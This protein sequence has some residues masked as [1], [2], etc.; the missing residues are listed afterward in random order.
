MR[1]IKSHLLEYIHNSINNSF[2]NKNI[3]FL[4]LFSTINENL[5]KDY[6]M[7]L[8]T[9]TIKDLYENSPISKKYRRQQVDNSDINKKIIQ[10]IY[11]E[12]NLDNLEFEVIKILNSTYKDL[13]I[14]FRDKYFNEFLEDIE[15]E[16]KGK[17]ETEENIKKYKENI[18]KLCLNYEDWFKKKN[19]RKRNK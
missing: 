16:E 13:L 17:G 8:M 10:Q 12:R 4:K 11:G 19:G 6:N 15:K 1:K 7:Q 3:Q 14:E 9:K 18:G 5:K 2:K